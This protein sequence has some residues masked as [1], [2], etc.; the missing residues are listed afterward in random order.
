MT[1]WDELSEEYKKQLAVWDVVVRKRTRQG[2]QNGQGRLIQIDVAEVVTTGIY[3]NYSTVL[4]QNLTHEEASI[5]VK[6]H[7]LGEGNGDS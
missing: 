4:G 5:I 2:V 1:K 6:I 3:S 7:N